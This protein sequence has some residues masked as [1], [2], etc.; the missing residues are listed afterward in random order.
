MLDLRLKVLKV[1][2]NIEDMLPILGI[3]GDLP[4][5]GYVFKEELLERE[6]DLVKRFLQATNLSRKI[7]EESDEEWDRIMKLTG[8][9]DKEMLI[10]IRDSFRKGIPKSEIETLNQNIAKAYDI[11]KIIGGKK[12]VGKGDRLAQGTIWNAN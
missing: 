6:Y 12:L 8:A 5:I 1:I 3:E 10:T 7:L 9:R 4:L 2:I 11:L